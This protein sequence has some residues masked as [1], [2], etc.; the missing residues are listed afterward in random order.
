V[1]ENSRSPTND[2][3]GRQGLDP[4]FLEAPPPLPPPAV[5]PPTETQTK[6]TPTP[7]PAPT[8]AYRVPF[9]DALKNELALDHAAANKHLLVQVE[10]GPTWLRYLV[11]IGGTCVFINA[12]FAMVLCVRQLGLLAVFQAF[13]SFIA[14]LFEAPPGLVHS[15]SCLSRSQEFFKD[16]VAFLCDLLSRGAFYVFQGTLW[17]CICMAL[18]NRGFHLLCALFMVT[19]GVLLA[20]ADY[21]GWARTVAAVGE[22]ASMA[23]GPRIGKTENTQD[24][25]ARLAEKEDQQYL[26]SIQQR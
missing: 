17:F 19:A 26:A 3:G 11:M 7:T 14:V 24:R 8:P 5:P 16:R 15:V 23:L 10:Q 21:L 9:A 18:S 2:G 6:P 13:F 25:L 12:C 22:E 1:S 4:S 20:V